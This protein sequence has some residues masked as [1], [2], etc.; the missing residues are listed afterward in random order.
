MEHYSHLPLLLSA[1]AV[2][3]SDCHYTEAFSQYQFL[4]P[5]ALLAGE[6]L[7]VVQADPSRVLGRTAYD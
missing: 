4:T 7:P 1:E 3:N 5:S 6:D 2:T